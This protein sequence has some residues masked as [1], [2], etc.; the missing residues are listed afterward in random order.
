MSAADATVVPLAHVMRGGTVESVH[1]GAAAVVDADGHVL[2]S[3]GSAEMLTFPRSAL[4]PFQLVGLLQLGSQAVKDMS[5][6]E[7]AVATGSHAGEP[8]HLEAVRRLL[9]RARVDESSLECGAHA[10]LDHRAAERLR[11]SGATPSPIHAQCSGQHAAMLLAARELGAPTK[12]YTSPDHPVQR[13]LRETLS[14]LCG[15]P[16]RAPAAIDGCGAPT[17]SLTLRQTAQ[18]YARLGR[19]A[20][21]PRNE[22]SLK[23]VGRAMRERPIY[24][25]GRDHHLDTEII[26]AGSL[27]A[28]TGSEGLFAVAHPSGLGF[29]LKVADGDPGRRALAPI[30]VATLIRL[31]WIGEPD[32]TRHLASFGPTVDVSNWS[33]RTVGRI[34]PLA[35]PPAALPG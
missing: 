19:P 17:Y 29:A 13:R 18:A 1:F 7:L 31:G 26:R 21:M 16:A 25:G 10:P 22:A 27:L 34:E 33:G 30:V 23:R 5:V 4:K 2:W 24:V 35:G 11:D 15:L 12:G 8:F 20:A 14:E 3:L 28:K 6:E 9:D 32:A